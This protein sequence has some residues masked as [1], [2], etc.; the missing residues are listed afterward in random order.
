MKLEEVINAALT[1][2]GEDGYDVGK[3]KAEDEKIKLLIKCVNI[4]LTEIAQ[5]Y[6]PLTDECKVIAK[7]NRFYYDEV[8][9]RVLR[10]TSVK[11]ENGVKVKFMQKSFWCNVGKNGALTVEYRYAPA[12][13]ATGDDCDV[14][15]R[16]S[17][18]TLA[19]GACAEYCMISGMYEQ[20]EGFAERFREDMRAC[21]RPVGSIVL[22]E[23]GWY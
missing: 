17:E 8:P 12:T 7:D 4:M 18:K 2:L 6:L 20:S 14:D 16:V 3:D 10:I 1:Y 5:E 13:V 21:V 11:D 23:R 19:L 9:R 22:K 15:P